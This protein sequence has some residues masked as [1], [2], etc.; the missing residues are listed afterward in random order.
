LEHPTTSPVVETFLH[1][2]YPGDFTGRD[3]R[4]ARYLPGLKQITVKASN[5]KA[6]QFITSVAFA[7]QGKS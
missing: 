4:D 2:S 6:K 7:F 3:A 5:A 1:Q